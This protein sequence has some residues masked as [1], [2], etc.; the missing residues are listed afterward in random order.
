MRAPSKTPPGQRSSVVGRSLSA[1]RMPSPTAMKYS[2]MSIFRMPLSAKYGFSGLETRTS[3]PSMSRTTASLLLAMGSLIAGGR[4]E[5]RRT[6]EAVHGWGE[7]DQVGVDRG[8]DAVGL[9]IGGV[10]VALPLQ[11]DT[12]VE[13]LGHVLR[14]GQ[15]GDR[16]TGVA[17]HQDGRA[18]LGVTLGERC[19][20]GLP[21][22]AAV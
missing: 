8:G 17:H 6:G 16:V 3:C 10:P 7:I 18:A 20:V 13:V 21:H 14:A 15:R 2:T 5:S 4:R 12:G 1:N 19:A 22:R 9:R 11:Q